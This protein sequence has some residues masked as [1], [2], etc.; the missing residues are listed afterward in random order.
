MRGMERIGR[1]FKR[2][3]LRTPANTRADNLREFAIPAADN[4]QFI[5]QLLTFQ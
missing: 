4:H 5:L 1:Q 3:T 2:S